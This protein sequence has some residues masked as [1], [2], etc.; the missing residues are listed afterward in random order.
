M[1]RTADPDT[2]K[3]VTFYIPTSMICQLQVLAHNPASGT[4]DVSAL[5]HEVWVKHIRTL[6]Q[7]YRDAGL[8]YTPPEVRPMKG[9]AMISDFRARVLAGDTISLE[10][11]KEALAALREERGLVVSTATNKDTG[12]KVKV[13]LPASIDDLF[14]KPEKKS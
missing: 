5:L 1:A 6:R 7:N 13:A 2:K 14:K 8:Q 12:K 4:S 10:E 11:Y 9:N 3:R